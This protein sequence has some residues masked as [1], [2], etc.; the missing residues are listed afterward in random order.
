M[1]CFRL[2]M[3]RGPVEESAPDIRDPPTPR[4]PCSGRKNRR[5]RKAQEGMKLKLFGIQFFIHQHAVRGLQVE[6][7]VATGF[8]LQDK[9][10]M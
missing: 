3:N 2:R 8:E 9:E 5:N 1:G 6:L 7:H 10:V 4:G